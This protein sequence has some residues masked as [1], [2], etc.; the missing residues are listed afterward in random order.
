MTTMTGTERFWYVLMC[1]AFGVVYFAKLPTTNTLSELPQFTGS[2]KDTEPGH[3]QVKH[4][5]LTN[6]GIGGSEV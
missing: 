5:L 4:A 6:A 2:A 1:I 3:Q